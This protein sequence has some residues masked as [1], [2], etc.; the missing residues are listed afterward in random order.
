M[1]E[2]VFGMGMG[3]GHG[4]EAEVVEWKFICKLPFGKKCNGLIIV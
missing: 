1:V 4:N 2:Q 3:N